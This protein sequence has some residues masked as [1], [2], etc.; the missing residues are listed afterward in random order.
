M[1]EPING[2]ILLDGKKV[3]LNN[4]NWKSLVGYVTQSVYLIDDSIKNN[5]LVGANSSSEFDE[6]RFNLA[7]KNSQLD[8]FIDQIPEGIN[9]KV[10]ENGI[11]LSGGQRQRIGIARTLYSNPKILILDEI[12]SSL[13]VKTAE[14]LLKSLIINRKNY[15][16]LYITQ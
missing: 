11:K 10:G 13:D 8:I 15:N 12:T 14:N 16:N 3:S 9:F 7:I 2:Q 1:L 5:I 6:K 4:Y